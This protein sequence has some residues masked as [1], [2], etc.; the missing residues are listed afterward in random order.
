MHRLFGLKVAGEEGQNFSLNYNILLVCQ[1]NLNTKSNTKLIKT[2]MANFVGA[3]IIDSSKNE[4]L[5]QQRDN[6]PVNYPL[7]WTLFGGGVE[8]GETV[9][10][11]VER[12]LKEE[13]GLEK[14]KI[15]SIREVQRNDQE[16]INVQYIYEVVLKPEVGIGDLKLQEGNDM[17]FFI[18]EKIFNSNL[19]FAF[20]IKTVLENYLLLHS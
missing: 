12:E 16:N 17:R 7:C 13:I 18:K 10:E 6:R 14:D 20:N 9:Q 15:L 3:I 4:I 2:G 5:L 19:Q 8:E 1:K 11:A